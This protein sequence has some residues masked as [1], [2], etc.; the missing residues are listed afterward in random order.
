MTDSQQLSDGRWSESRSNLSVFF[1]NLTVTHR[2]F[3]SLT[4]GFLGYTSSPIF[5]ESN[6]GPIFGVHDTAAPTS[7]P[8]H[9]HHNENTHT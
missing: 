7:C 5:E 3:Q 1:I 2:V 6:N 9:N 4:S 8:A